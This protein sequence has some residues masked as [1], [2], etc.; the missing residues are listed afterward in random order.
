MTVSG[1]NCRV[2]KSSSGKIILSMLNKF[3][4]D[5]K[6]IKYNIKRRPLK[7]SRTKDLEMN[8]MVDDKNKMI[9]ILNMIRY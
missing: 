4:Q 1:N 6:K 5:K 7:S 3:W 2:N 8:M 9:R